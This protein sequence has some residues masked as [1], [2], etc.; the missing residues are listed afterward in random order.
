M[1][2]GAVGE[3][4][5]GGQMLDEQIDIQQRDRSEH[6]ESKEKVRGDEGRGRQGGERGRALHTKEK[7]GLSHE[8]QAT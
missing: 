5:G 4:G 6:R 2:M 1:I 3:W 8:W 7:P